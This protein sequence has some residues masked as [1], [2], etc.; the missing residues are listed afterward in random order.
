[1]KTKISN[2]IALILTLFIISISAISSDAQQSKSNISTIKSSGYAPVNGLKMYYE[3]HGEGKPIV[4][5]HGSYMSIDLNYGQLIP[6]LAKSHKVIALEMQGHGRTADI[7]RPFS[8]VAL[9]DDVDGLLKYLHI[10][11]ADV[12]GYS[13]GATVGLELAIR[14]P[15]VVNKLV[16][17]SSAY[18]FEGWSKATRDMLPTLKPE[19][20]EKTPL[21]TDYDRL[22]PDKNHWKQF[23][24]K[25][26][27]FDAT[28]FD[29]GAENIKAIKS[30]VL[31]INGDNDG[32]DLSHVAD[33]YKLCGGSVF[34]DMVG[35]PKS[36][37]AIVPAATHVSLMMET[38][39]LASL[40]HPFLNK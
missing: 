5:L 28:P 1:M 18:K 37:L 34:A 20:F 24:T 31:I 10:D 27:Q 8:F 35:L 6:D 25:L 12:L 36:Q 15:A 4:L 21:K 19:F 17:I 7:D 39:K 40:I 2:G 22:A 3:I 14:H 32:V 26:L 11:S 23:V 9:A 30:P 29:L 16:F 38:Q 33:L 13:L